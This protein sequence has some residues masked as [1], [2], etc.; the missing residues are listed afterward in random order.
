M[1]VCKPNAVECFNVAQDLAFPESA[2][3]DPRDWLVSK[4]EL[5]MA[6]MVIPS[7][8]A[9]ARIMLAI[10]LCIASAVGTKRDDVRVVIPQ[11]FETDRSISYSEFNLEVDAGDL[12][13][14]SHPMWG[15]V[16][17]C[18]P[19]A[20]TE[21]EGMYDIAAS[22]LCSAIAKQIVNSDYEVAQVKNVPN[23]HTVDIEVH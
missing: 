13:V 23:H 2:N 16:E 15:L 19:Y 22:A 17:I 1:K 5:D 11:K 12:I 9:M 4:K 7:D 10:S 14:R 21:Q 20:V 18:L 8:D 6:K 3:V